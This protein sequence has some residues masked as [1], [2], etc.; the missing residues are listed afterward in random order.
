MSGESPTRPFNFPPVPPVLVP[1]ATCPRWS[2]AATPMVPCFAPRCSSHRA[3]WYSVTSEPGAMA[4]SPWLRAKASAPSP[5]SN[6]WGLESITRRA[7]VMG[8]CTVFTTATAPARRASPSINE[9]S[10]STSPSALSTAPVPELKRGSSSSM[11]AATSTASSAGPPFA[12][13]AAPASAARRH[14][15]CAPA[16]S[17]WVSPGSCAAMHDDREHTLAS[18]VGRPFDGEMHASPSDL[19]RHGQR[20]ELMQRRQLAQLRKSKRHEG[21]HR[22]RAHPAADH[23]QHRAEERRGGA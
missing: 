7:R 4:G 17:F 10:S 13:T 8:F 15:S 20:L 21:H 22:Q 11:R 23:R 14:P 5:T 9:A 18:A 6:T 1:A 3:R 16:P 12:S 2:T 19:G